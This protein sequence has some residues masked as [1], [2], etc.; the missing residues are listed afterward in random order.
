MHE[1]EKD[2]VN[3]SLI[4]FRKSSIQE[5]DNSMVIVKNEEKDFSFRLSNPKD[6]FSNGKVEKNLIKIK[7]Q[8][9]KPKPKPKPLTLIVNSEVIN[10]KDNEPSREN[11]IIPKLE[12][13]HKQST[14]PN[15]APNNNLQY[16][17][18]ITAR[19][20]DE[21]EKKLTNR[22]NSSYNQAQKQSSLHKILEI[23]PEALQIP[24]DR[25]VNRTEVKI[26][27]QEL[28]SSTFRKPEDYVSEM[29]M[30]EFPYKMCLF[31]DNYFTATSSTS[32]E[33]GHMFCFKCG[34]C[35]FEE[36]IEE[37]E[38][39]L[40]CPYFR[41]NF[42]VDVETIKKLVTSKHIEN[43]LKRMEQENI[44]LLPQKMISDLSSPSKGDA[45][46]KLYSQKHVFDITNNESFR[47]FNRAKDQFCT[48]CY[49]PSL[50]GKSGKKFVKCLNCLHKLCK[51]C[52]KEYTTEHFNISGFNYCKVFYRKRTSGFQTSRA[53]TCKEIC[54]GTILF[55][56]GYFVFILG[57]FKYISNF[58]VYLLNLEKENGKPIDRP[59][60]IQFSLY[61]VYIFLML[62]SVIVVLPLLF[63]LYPWFSLIVYLWN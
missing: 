2:R 19:E 50:Y 40:K 55:F 3:R 23:E 1:Y 47:Y 49:E 4:V 28:S 15:E 29:M 61:L 11:P 44:I 36:K 58:F 48:R 37:G 35:F 62:V 21:D 33:C 27:N 8:I 42:L 30:Q 53:N 52:G 16:N 17:L 6:F 56:I 46:I 39:T 54:L 25:A 63:F 26:V 34:K 12:L 51:F 24:K 45:R 13:I 18:I 38:K 43:Y 32:A 5:R 14:S 7:S 22:V 10:L 9:P 31:C 57:V 60:P 41:C 59:K 20:N